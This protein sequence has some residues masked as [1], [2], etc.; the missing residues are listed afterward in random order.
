MFRKNNMHCHGL[1]INNAIDIKIH[2]LISLKIGHLWYKY[3]C[4]SFKNHWKWVVKQYGSRERLTWLI[5][6]LQGYCQSI[7]IHIWFRKY[8]KGS[9][10]HYHTLIYYIHIWSEYTWFL[11]QF[12]FKNQQWQRIFFIFYLFYD[13]MQLNIRWKLK[14]STEICIS[15]VSSSEYNS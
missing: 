9:E 4:F 5:V 15:P 10:Y 12:K 1:S 13:P 11:L 8:I 7:F 2:I 14:Y 6:V 3:I